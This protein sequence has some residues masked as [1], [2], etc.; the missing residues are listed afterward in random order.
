MHTQRRNDIDCLLLVLSAT[1]IDRNMCDIFHRHFHFIFYWFGFARFCH[2]QSS[3]CVY[4]LT[5]KKLLLRA[6]AKMV[7]RTKIFTYK[8][9]LVR[10]FEFVSR[11]LP[12]LICHLKNCI[13]QGTSSI[14]WIFIINNIIQQS[15][16]AQ[17]AKEITN[18][19]TIPGTV[20][21]EHIHQTSR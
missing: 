20:N 19:K 17:L 15:T 5:K 2:E 12:L 8:Y 18:A 21:E 14:F 13:A 9:L 7:E 1:F 10:S 3:V 16:Y 11:H 6:C 4:I